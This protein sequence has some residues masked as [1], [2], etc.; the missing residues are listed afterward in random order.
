[1]VD[2]DWNG[3]LEAVHQDGQ[4][5]SLLPLE[6]HLNAYWDM[7]ANSELGTFYIRSGNAEVCL[8]Q[9]GDGWTIRNTAT[10]EARAV[11]LVKKIATETSLAAW[12][13]HTAVARAILAEMSPPVDPD[14]LEAREVVAQVHVSSGYLNNDRRAL[15]RG[16]CDYD[17]PVLIAL[18][19]IKRGI[20]L[21]AQRD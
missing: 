19:A 11:E 7:K 6:K 1:M 8:C 13:D 5:V 3:A 16:D 17:Q 20:A 18:A 12:L 2:V 14:L 15:D 10:P 9:S 4:V 21:A